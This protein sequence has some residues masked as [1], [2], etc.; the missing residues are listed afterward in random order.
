ME[1]LI[2]LQSSRFQNIL[3]DRVNS[4]MTG[5]MFFLLKQGSTLTTLLKKLV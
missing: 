5:F 3:L 1:G 4:K 2:S